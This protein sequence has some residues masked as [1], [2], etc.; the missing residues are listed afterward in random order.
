MLNQARLKT[1][2]AREDHI[3]NVLDEATRRLAS[4]PNDPNKYQAVLNGLILSS[5]YQ[6]CEGECALR[7]RQKDLTLVEQML[8]TCVDEAKK[9]TKRDIKVQIDKQNWLPADSAGGVDLYAKGGKIRVVSTLENRLQ[10]VSQK[11]VPEIRS[12]LFGANQNR[13]FND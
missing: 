4:L 7:C 11:M 13:K 3:N 5:L 9:V 10:L 12:T 6:I 2:K 8:P 1:L